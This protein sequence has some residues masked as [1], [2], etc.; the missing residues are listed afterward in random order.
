MEFLWDKKIASTLQTLTRKN[1]FKFEKSSR[2]GGL[3]QATYSHKN[4]FYISYI[5]T[6]EGG[7]KKGMTQ[8]TLMKWLLTSSSHLGR[9]LA[10]LFGLL[11]HQCVGMDQGSRLRRHAP[12]SNQPVA[13]SVKARSIATLLTRLLMK[14]LS[15]KCPDSIKVPRLRSVEFHI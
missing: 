5:E 9:A 14:G 8:I 6:G 12:N 1:F 15:W 11:V 10:E 13:P 2:C 4:R 7:N 3:V